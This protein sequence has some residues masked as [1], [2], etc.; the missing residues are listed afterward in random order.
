MIETLK[1]FIQTIKQPG[2]IKIINTSATHSAFLKAVKDYIQ[3]VMVHVAILIPIMHYVDV[4]KKNGLLIGVFYFIIYI[5]SSRS[6]QLSSKFTQRHKHK[7]AN[8][9]LYIGFI[10]G[11]LTG[12][13]YYK[14]LWI[15][16]LI[17]FT[18]IFIAE[19]IRKPALTGFVADNSPGEVLTSVISAQ[20]LL[21]T[22]LTSLFA[23]TFGVLAEQFNIG[24]ALLIISLFLVISTLLT[25]NY[26]ANRK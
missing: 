26:M 1:S 2:L 14:E 3:P 15:P 17:T 18:G 16:A 22:I 12:I 10:S 5:L 8:I 20:S 24:V 9:T 11:V 6:S 25:N 4:E 19:N 21:K 7:I 13:F 23:L